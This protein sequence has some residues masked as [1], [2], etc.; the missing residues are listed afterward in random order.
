MLLVLLGGLADH[1][2][3]EQ[4]ERFSAGVG[5]DDDGGGA[6]DA[7]LRGGYPHSFAEDM[8]F[9]DTLQRGEEPVGHLACIGGFGGEVEGRGLYQ[10]NRVTGLD[11]PGRFMRSLAVRSSGYASRPSPGRARNRHSSR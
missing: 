2:R 10:E 8:V 3:V 9:A 1:A 11:D 7:D 4:D 6:G 5:W